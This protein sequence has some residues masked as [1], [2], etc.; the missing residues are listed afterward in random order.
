MPDPLVGSPVRTLI[1]EFRYAGRL[2]LKTPG[3]TAVAILVLALGIGA[4]T[5]IFSIV[6]AMVLAPVASDHPSIVGIYSRNTTRPDTYRSFSW[7]EYE[8][9][10]DGGEPFDR[11]MAFTMTM[12]GAGEGE[13]TRRSFA[14]IVSANYFDTLGVS[15]A[16]GRSFTDDEQRPGAAQRVVIVGH[17]YARLQGANPAD[18]V[19]RS[20][21]INGRDYAIVGVTPEGFA[22]TMALVS[23]EF[24]LPTG[25][26]EALAEQAFTSG[27]GGTLSDP[28]YRPLMLVGRLRPGQTI[29]GAQPILASLSRR[30][31][32]DDPVGYKNQE[33]MVQRLSRLSVSTSPRDDSGTS[34]V[35]FLLMG[36]S[37][38]V[39]VIA[40]LN[41]AN[42]L[43]ARGTSR[44]RETALRLAL[45]S[46][47]GR[48]V[49]QLLA[50][51]LLL[52]VL[53]GA[54]GLLLAMW[55]TRLL[56]ATFAQVLPMVVTF[57][58]RPD[59][60]VL[61]ATLGFSLLAT[62][63]AGLGPAWRTT[64]T[65]VLPDLKEQPAEQAS[66]RWFSM[67]NL[68][69][70]GQVALSLALLTA[71]GLFMR[72]AVK[73]AVA[74]PGFPLE[75]GL[76][77][78]IDPSLGGYDETRGRASLRSILHR[79]RSTPGVQSA[80]V[81]S[82]VPFGEFQEGRLVQKAGTP[83]AAEGERDAGVDAT[84]V[85]IGAAYFETL[86]LPV[87]RGRGFTTAEEESAGGVATAI[88]DEPLARQLFAGE[89]PIGQRIQ[90]PKR[91]SRPDP[92]PME[93]VGV[94]AG[95]RHDMFDKAPV[96]HIYV[97]AGR[98]YRGG[99]N[100][101]V[102]VDT[103]APAVEGALL[104]TLRTEI[105][106]VDPDVPIVSMQSLRQHRDNSIMLWAVNS[107]A[108]L[109]SV[110]GGVALLLAVIGVYGVKSYVVSRRTREIGIRMALGATPGSVLW[111]VIREG[112][113]LTLTG[114]AIGL[115]L[116]W[117]VATG[118]SHMLYEVSPL[119]PVV[120]AVA[121]VMLV[122]A[123]L[124]ATYVPARRATHVRPMTAL[125]AE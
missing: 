49:R 117:A 73:A 27:G 4:N 116:S 71:A 112:L 10:R 51:S 69:V 81:A 102:R 95:V 45:G 36:M 54:A 104:G 70:V 115:L 93:I 11:V 85:V 97:P 34:A 37:S 5:A 3:F 22:G 120:F 59:L 15:L 8:R 58:A 24:W 43:L 29:E 23:P 92:G 75:G 26:Y 114:V 80:S 78:R 106:S 39:L 18:V 16:A 90:F 9:L 91:E 105:R 56:T 110:F 48:V 111:L 2:L 118:L 57:D 33:L 101:H 30:L 119:D 38:L 19:G 108:R 64:R 14:S 100:L 107:G 47:R 53:G 74:D 88:I 35:W 44:R 113:T 25:A 32:Q 55:G 52:A 87:M 46:G 84:Y 50:E 122:A 6:N 82:I 77:V 124:L 62:L 123:A 13:S 72:G 21:R 125:R 83:P 60:R 103:T 86:R 65:D 66:G 98:N 42:M 121:P 99:M 31:E 20:I 76:V 12:V 28:A 96:P 61:A 79:V 109:F 1:D 41:L 17:P 7:Q 67:R 68:L 94:A 63:T 40:C 89:D